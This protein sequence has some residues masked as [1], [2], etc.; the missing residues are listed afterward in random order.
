MTTESIFSKFDMTGKTAIITGAAGLL[1]RQF[2]IAL[3]QAG[4]N[5]VLA[6]LAGDIA[7]QNANELND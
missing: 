7:T 2:S 5:V 6:D 3:A 4:A 1:G